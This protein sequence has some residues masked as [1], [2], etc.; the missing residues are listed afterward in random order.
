MTRRQAVARLILVCL[1]CGVSF[2]I[3]KATLAF[4][5]PRPGGAQIR[6]GLLLECGA[7]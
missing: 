7:L 3:I 1:V 6:P 2:T 5:S 4:T